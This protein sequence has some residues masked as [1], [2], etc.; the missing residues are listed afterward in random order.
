MPIHNEDGFNPKTVV[1][2]IKFW[3]IKTKTPGVENPTNLS[4]NTEE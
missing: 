4:Y 2:C 1:L 3:I